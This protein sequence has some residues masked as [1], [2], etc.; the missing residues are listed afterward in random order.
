MAC[1]IFINGAMKNIDFLDKNASRVFTVMLFLLWLFIWA[2]FA[3]S[4]V[5]GTYKELHLKSPIKSFAVGTW[6]A[7]TSVT[8][9]AVFQ[10]IPQMYLLAYFLL[11]LNIAIWIFYLGVIIKGYKRIFS[12]KLSNKVNGVLLI[13]TVSTQSL[14]VL[15]CT[16]FDKN[17]LIIESRTLIL[18]GVLFYVFAFLLIL[19]RYFS[20]NSWNIEDDWQNT[21]CILHG[22]MSITGL[23]CSVSGAVKGSLILVIW[24]WV[25]ACF[26]IVE[27]IEIIRAVNRINKYGFLR[28]VAVYDVTQW[29]RIFTFGMLYTFTMKFDFKSAR[30]SNNLLLHLKSFILQNGTW[31]MVII[32]LIE[33]ILF[34][35]YERKNKFNIQSK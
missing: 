24:L 25:L 23:A 14:V 15:G 31:V 9:I 29:S 32:L 30:V 26:F 33:A 7:G 28:G 11:F 8:G 2:S 35:G 3:Q 34:F 27:V 1:G 10:R 20:N 6:V 18:L 21:N 22:A 16:I 13:S 19:K 5:N 12:G 4:L 17:S